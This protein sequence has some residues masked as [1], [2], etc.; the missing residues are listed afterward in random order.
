LA[1]EHSIASGL[2]GRYA[3]ALFE[4]AL[5]E[6][7]IDQADEDL[8]RVAS[9][10]RESAEFR[11]AA[12]S[13]ALSRGQQGDLMARVAKELELS[14]LVANFLG[15]LA[16]N[17]R[18]AELRAIID[19]FS[20]LVADHKG[21]VRAEVRTAKPLSDTQTD[22]LKAKLAKLAGREVTI[23]ASVDESLIGGLVVRIGS[24]MID[25]S[26]ATKLATLERAMKGV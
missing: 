21:E 4:L 5:D 17:R 10:L 13:P 20:A 14:K 16:A 12:Q 11:Y 6:K 1:Q 15:V 7:A 8:R 2:A 23:D 3:T 26:V 24:R 18:L 19:T 9:L 22:A 25:G